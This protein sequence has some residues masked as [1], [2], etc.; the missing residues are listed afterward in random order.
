MLEGRMPPFILI[1]SKSLPRSGLHY[2]KNTLAKLLQA[3][4]S[5]CEWYNE[6]GCCKKMPCVLTGYAESC[7]RTNTVKIRLIKSHDFKLADTVFQPMY[8]VRRIILVRD[9]LFLLTSWFALEHLR[10]YEPALAKRRI[11]LKKIWL[12]H[13]QEMLT[14]AYKVMDE[15]FSPPSSKALEEWLA[16]K[17]NYI[18]GF[19]EKWVHPAIQ[20]KHPYSKVVRYDEIN[21][22]I[23]DLIAEIKDY[24]SEKQKFYINH[25]LNEIDNQ[26]HERQDPYKVTSIKLSSY[27]ADNSH[28]FVELAKRIAAADI[29]GVMNS[30][31][32]N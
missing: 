5:F 18:I 8:C 1:D 24:L 29:H 31:Q 4:F 12:H 28:I 9:P 30:T 19:L 6:P 16:D 20:E 3:Q 2:M 25:L 23:K 11:F 22:L 10:D 21:S 26:F 27:L 15:E 14:S 13:E 7:I 17:T 32:T